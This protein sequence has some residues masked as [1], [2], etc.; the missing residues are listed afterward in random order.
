MPL[1]VL[2]PISITKKSLS[3]ALSIAEDEKEKT[4]FNMRA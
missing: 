3:H 1:V 4:R 2:E